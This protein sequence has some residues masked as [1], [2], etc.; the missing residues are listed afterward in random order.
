MCTGPHRGPPD[1]IPLGAMSRAPPSATCHET[2]HPTNPTDAV[3][4]RTTSE[5]AP[6][7][8]ADRHDTENHNA[9]LTYPPYPCPVAHMVNLLS[10]STRK[11]IIIFRILAVGY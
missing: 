4:G 11:P 9:L 8:D 1:A 10:E 2:R 6:T 3:G 5:Q 7:H